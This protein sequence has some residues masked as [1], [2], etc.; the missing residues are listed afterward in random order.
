MA[1]FEVVTADVVVL[2]VLFEQA[3]SRGKDMRIKANEKSTMSLAFT[4]NPLCSSGGDQP[5]PESF[6]T[7][8]I[9]LRFLLLS[10]FAISSARRASIDETPFWNCVTSFMAVSRGLVFL[11]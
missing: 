4:F 8:V 10:K 2:D 1:G 11:K 9:I 6:H 7:L 3:P 5:P